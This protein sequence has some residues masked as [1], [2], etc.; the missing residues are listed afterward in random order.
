MAAFDLNWIGMQRMLMGSMSKNL[1]QT[2]LAKCDLGEF[3]NYCTNGHGQLTDGVSAG[4]DE[5]R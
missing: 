1:K 3:A 5:R 4:G 2:N